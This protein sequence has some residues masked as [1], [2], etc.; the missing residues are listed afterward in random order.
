MADTIKYVLVALI[1]GGSMGAFYFFGDHSLLMRVI[2][3]LVAAGVRALRR[4]EGRAR[5][6]R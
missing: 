4:L 5:G 2:G 1:V 6:G 3:L